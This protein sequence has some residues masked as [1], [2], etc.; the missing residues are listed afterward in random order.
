MVT[1][2]LDTKVTVTEPGVVH[3]LPMIDYLA[4]PV[5]EGSLSSHGARLLLPPSCPAKFAWYRDH[6]EPPKTAYDIGSAAHDALLGGGPEIVVVDADNWMTKRAKEQ[7]DEARARGAVPI[8]AADHDQVTAMVEAVWAHPFANALLSGEGTPEASLFAR[9]PQTGV[10]LRARLDWLPD[11]RTGRLLLADY[12]TCRSAQQDDFMKAAVNYGYHQQLPFY[13]MIARLLGLA[14]DV[15][16]LF[17]AQENTPPYLVNVIQLPVTAQRI[18]DH[19]NRKAIDLYAQCAAT[20]T[21]PGYSDDV[22]IGELPYWYEKQYDGV[23][24]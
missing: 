16:C 7:R 14:D 18:G 24:S 10:M 9:D 2:A 17:V 8:L 1:P 5:P 11:R 6:P 13:A 19:L 12:K 15:K 4:D 23:L 21:W 22:V 3:D 20:D